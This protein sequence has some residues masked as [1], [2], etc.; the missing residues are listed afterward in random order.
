M[1]QFFRPKTYAMKVDP[2]FKYAWINIPKN[3]SS[4]IQKTLSDNGWTDVPE[5]NIDE[6]IESPNYK[7]LVVLRDPVERWISG[8]SQCAFDQHL[9]ILEVLDN[10]IFWRTILLNPVFDDHTEYQH[11]FVGNAQ[12]LV[13]VYMDKSNPNDFYKSFS[14]WIRTTGGVAHF[15]TWID[16]VNPANSNKR[17]FKINEALIELFINGSNTD[18]IKKVHEIDYEMFKKYDR[19]TN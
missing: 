2:T 3:G 6:I 17:K 19:F 12:N 14:V 9:R 5:D 10:K 8:F 16:P 7:K 4:F 11:R 15:D 13:Y 1:A 18:S